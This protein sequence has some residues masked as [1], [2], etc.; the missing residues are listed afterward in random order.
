M[1]TVPREGSTQPTMIVSSVPSMTR[2]DGAVG[3][4]CAH[5]VLTVASAT[6]AVM[7]SVMTAIAVNFSVQPRSAAK[8]N[9]N[10]QHVWGGGMGDPGR[11]FLTKTQKILN[12]QVALMNHGARTVAAQ[13]CTGLPSHQCICTAHAN[14]PG[15][16]ASAIVT[17]QGAR[18]ST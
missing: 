8:K 12:N 4:P 11:S 16:A 5:T 2:S 3:A 10:A 14:I 17:L 7:H 15:P 18:R 13:A 6:R 9:E 1:Q